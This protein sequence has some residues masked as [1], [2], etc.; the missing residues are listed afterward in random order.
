MTRPEGL[1]VGNGPSVS[2]SVAEQVPEETA[3]FVAEGVTS[4]LLQEV[5]NGT[6]SPDMPSRFKNCFLFIPG[7]I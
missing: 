7:I 2:E 6:M 1:F 3:A 5:S 4:S